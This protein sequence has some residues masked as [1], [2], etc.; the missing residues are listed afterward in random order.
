MWTSCS[1]STICCRQR[2]QNP[3]YDWGPLKKCAEQLKLILICLFFF[4]LIKTSCWATFCI[5]PNLILIHP[6]QLICLQTKKEPDST[7]LHLITN[8][9]TGGV[10]S[11]ASLS[12]P[13]QSPEVLLWLVSNKQ[14]RPI[15]KMKISNG[16]CQLRH[17]MPDR[18]EVC[19]IMM[20]SINQFG[21]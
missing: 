17:L 13:L 5:T 12:C 14:S 4:W 15:L 9:I 16:H 21:F 18:V 3:F 1:L 2:G 8:N 20:Q 11:K 6:V 19:Y 10:L 7:F